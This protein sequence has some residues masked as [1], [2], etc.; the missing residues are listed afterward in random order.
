MVEQHGL[1][2]LLAGRCCRILLDAG[3]LSADEMARGMSLA[4]SRANEPLHQVVT[5]S[6]NRAARNRRPRHN[7]MDWPRTIR[8]NLKHYQPAY[9]TIIPAVRIGYGHKR[10]APCVRSSCALTRA[11][12]WRRRLSMR[13]SAA[14]C[15]LRCPRSRRTW[16]CLIHRSWI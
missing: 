6:L 10:A 8:A 4:L 14:R 9:R 1:H 3:A 5:G 13:A 11:A 7:E 15:S 16:S 2:G 12:R